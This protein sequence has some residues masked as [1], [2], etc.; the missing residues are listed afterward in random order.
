MAMDSVTATE[1]DYIQY[2]FVGAFLI[3]IELL[4]GRLPQSVHRANKIGK[5]QI[6]P[7][8]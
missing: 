8:K 6:E 7:E 1:Y 2:N 5:K 3:V 4:G